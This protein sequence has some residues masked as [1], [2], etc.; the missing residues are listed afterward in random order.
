MPDDPPSDDVVIGLRGIRAV[1]GIVSVSLSE[2]LE[3]V[4]LPQ[5]RALVLLRSAGPM[6]VG[7]LAELLRISPSGATRAAARMDRGGWVARVRAEEDRR[8]VGLRLT[9]K[10]EALVD[11]VIRARRGELE[12]AFARMTDE[13]RDTVVRGLGMLADSV[14]EPDHDLTL[15]MLA[16]REEEG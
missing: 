1:V 9:P 13:Q 3:Q 16:L 7:R 15:L 10:G 2:A 5:L 4:T 12:A 11:A 6:Q 14:Q 8:A